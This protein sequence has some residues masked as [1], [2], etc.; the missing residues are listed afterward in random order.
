MVDLGELLNINKTLHTKNFQD[1]VVLS[2]ILMKVTARYPAYKVWVDVFYKL[3][4]QLNRVAT[5]LSKSN[6]GTPSTT[7]TQHYSNA[8]LPQSSQIHNIHTQEN[9]PKTVTTDKSVPPSAPSETKKPK[10][11]PSVVDV[12]TILKKPGFTIDVNDKLRLRRFLNSPLSK[13]PAYSRLR[14]RII[15]KL[16]IQQENFF[17]FL[18]DKILENNILY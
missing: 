9:T 13:Q 18:F 2:Q 15:K 4:D 8:P 14:N 1:P 6:T 3:Q 17:G 16:N 7:T 5:V 12:L 11:P 10:L